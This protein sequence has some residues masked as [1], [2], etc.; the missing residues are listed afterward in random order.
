MNRLRMIVVWAAFVAAAAPSWIRSESSIRDWLVLGEFEVEEKSSALDFDFLNGEALVSP[1]AGN[2]TGGRF[3]FRVRSDAS[4]LD[5]LRTDIPF[6]KRENTVAYSAFFVYSPK[7]QPAVLLCGSDDGIAVWLNRQRIHRNDADRSCTPDEDKVEIRLAEGWNT[8]LF[9]VR[10][11]VGGWGVSAR[12]VDAESIAFS[13]ENPFPSVDVPESPYDVF[14]PITG[15]EFGIDVMNRSYLRLL[16]PVVRTFAE[17]V[18]GT[19]LALAGSE[20]DLQT[21]F[22]LAD[23][24]PG[25]TVLAEVLVP[26][27]FALE[28]TING[29]SWTVVFQEGTRRF[30]IQAQPLIRLDVLELFFEPWI[31]S[32]WKEIREGNV[33]VFERILSVPAL[34]SGLRVSAMADIGRAWGSFSANGRILVPRFSRDSGDRTITAGPSRPKSR[35]VLRVAIDGL[36]DATADAVID[37]AVHKEKAAVEA[38][39][40]VVHHDPIESYVSGVRYSDVLFGEDFPSDPALET[41]LLRLILEGNTDRAAALLEEPLARLGRRTA[42]MKRYTVSLFGNAHIDMAWLWRY[43]E[44]IEVVRSTFASALDNLD[45]YPGFRFC[46]G[47]AQS[48]FWME[49]LHPDLFRRIQ[50]AVNS[51]RWEIVGGSWCQPDDNMA[52]GE[53]LVRQYLYGKKY[54]K[55]KFNKDVR[56][57]WMPDTFGHAASLPQILSKCGIDAFVF[58]RPWEEERIFRWQSADGSEVLGMRPPAWYN[59][60][61]SADIGKLP[62]ATEKKFGISNTLYCFGVGDHGGGPTARDIETAIKLDRTPGFPNIR[63]AD[64]HGYFRDLEPYRAGLEIFQGEINFVFEGCWTSQAMVKAFNRRLEAKLP[65]TET[66]SMFAGRMGLPCSQGDLLRAW[67]LVMFNQ[68]HDIF[69]GSGIGEIYPDA[70]HFYET[71]D[72]L[73]GSVL[74]QSLGVLSRAVD[75]R[76]PKRGLRPMVVFNPLNALRTD[77]LEIGLDVLG[78]ASVR[79]FD[80]QG[81]ILKS[82][83]TGENR[84][85]VS[86]PPIPGVGYKTLFYSFDKPQKEKRPDSNLKLENRFLK[87]TVDPKSGLVSSIFDKTMEREILKQPGNV[88]SL[89]NDNSGSMTAWVVKLDGSKE[90]LDRPSSLSVVESNAM[91]KVVRVVFRAE[92]SIF[93]Q[94]IVLYADQP[95]IDFVIRADW[96]HRDTMLKVAFPLA[97]AGEATFETPYGHIIRDQTGKEVVSQKWVDVSD[98]VWGVSLLND[99]KYGFDVWDNVLRMSLLRSPHDPD[100]KADEGMHEIRY[101]LF[102]HAGDWKQGGT[103]QA[104]WMY[105]TPMQAFPAEVHEGLLGAEGMFLFVDSDHVILSACKKAEDSDRMVLRLFEAEGRSGEVKI[106]FDRPVVRAMETDMME[107]DEKDLGQSGSSI[108]VPIHANEVKTLVLEFQKGS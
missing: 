93:E 30:S 85:I 16:V 74:D 97:V 3:W 72:S 63:F 8:F 2:R 68:F 95:R 70:R 5:F 105:N 76:P 92:P 21:G 14:A 86:P 50:A 9:K 22:R 104:A 17:S 79:F 36:H 96:H 64:V 108:I 61:V 103:V 34:F 56:I 35:I 13:A 75:T 27:A 71:A 45:R 48:Y 52:S 65:T 60:T 58:F 88:L 47:Q 26:A 78:S 43:P 57:G 102:P 41:N 94:D 90:I 18:G 83:K 42:E 54:F 106:G 101:A 44:T 51:G 1:R 20:T 55:E 99:S 82:A 69:D 29:K 33:A 67:R 46:H 24:S 66:F 32:D 25:E 81:K 40:L 77:P 10:N 62:L 73:A 91:R 12:I 6:S 37:T 100:S 89:Q 98:S 59:N 49:E 84:W 53:S 28:Q 11:G 31:L 23:L 80:G 87:V 7:T 4:V 15:L 38:S 39:C 107:E 19:E